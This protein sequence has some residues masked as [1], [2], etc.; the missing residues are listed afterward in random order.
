MMKKTTHNIIHEGSGSPRQKPTSSFYRKA[1]QATKTTAKIITLVVA[2]TLYSVIGAKK[3]NAQNVPIKF[4]G[5][6]ETVDA[7]FK[8]AMRKGYVGFY[9]WADSTG[10]KHSF[11]VD[12]YKQLMAVTGKDSVYVVK[13]DENS[14][15]FTGKEMVGGELII[16]LTKG[17]VGV[18]PENNDMS[19]RRWVGGVDEDVASRHTDLENKVAIQVT[20]KKILIFHSQIPVPI[21]LQVS[22]VLGELMTLKN[23][24]IDADPVN[25]NIKIIYSDGTPVIVIHADAKGSETFIE[26][27]DKNTIGSR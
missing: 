18:R 8:T 26:P 12:I 23:P 22:E 10:E 2:I 17:M 25:P 3:T 9:N 1:W 21:E 27:Y 20:S 4:A 5:Q 16:F 7:D 15:E 6:T 11:A 24:K 14:P 13:M 19:A